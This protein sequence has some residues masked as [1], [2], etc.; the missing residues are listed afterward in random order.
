MSGTESLSP[1]AIHKE[2]YA[3]GKRARAAGH[4]LANLDANQKNAI[5]RAMAAEL[6]SQATGI[7]SENAKD[8][9]EGRENGLSSAMLDRL[10]LN[11]SR[12]EAMADGVEQVAQL[13]DPVGDILDEKERPNGMKIQQVRVPIGVIGIIF[14]SR[15]NVT[16]DAAVLCLKS[17]NATILRGGSEAIHSN[18]A[19]CDALQ[20]GG[21]AEGLPPSSIQL[22]PFTD[23][24]SVKEMASMDR[25]LDLII[26]RGGKGLIETVVSLAR[27][28]VIKHYDGICHVFVDEAADLEM[29]RLITVDAKTQKPGVCN[30]L[31]TLLVHEEVAEKLLPEVA[32]S[33]AC[34]GVEL[35]ACQRAEEILG[36]VVAAAT[37]EDWRAEYLD[38]ILSIKVVASK[39]EA[40]EHINLYG[41]HHTDCI[42]TGDRES[43]EKFLREVDSACTFHNLSTRF[44]D[45]EEFGFGAEIGISTDKI[46]ARGPMAL[47][48]LT[49]YQ[50]RVRGDGQLKE[51]P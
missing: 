11:E 27:M 30:A 6:R 14:E 16:S 7:L 2:I 26:P 12:L 5:L 41:S 48:E 24:E 47:R 42:V 22:V 31:E 25:Y 32:S 4:A 37:E 36:E 46:H 8:L 1:E 29:A 10:R 20:A 3:M 45:G 33:L 40:I 34:R 39:E 49:S 21:E 15:P 35:R 28:P 18:R 17:G 44:S 38:L 23:R 9:E 43:A 51:S 13:S 50:Y 19:I